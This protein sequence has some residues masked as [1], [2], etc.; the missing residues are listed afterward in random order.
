MSVNPN[1]RIVLTADGKGVTNTIKQ[2]KGEL[3]SLG[4]TSKST[5]DRSATG[6]KGYE[7]SIRS[8]KEQTKQLQVNT[9][10]LATGMVG[11]GTGIAAAYTSISN[12]AKATAR[13]E[14]AEVAVMRIE[15]Q[16]ATLRQRMNT[17]TQ[18]G[19]AGTEKYIVTVQKLKTAMTDLAIK[20]K[21]VEINAGLVQDTYI[22]FSTSVLNTA[23]SSMFIMQQSLKGVSKAM[24]A[25][26]FHM[27]TTMPIIKA[28]T[29]AMIT[30]GRAS[31]FTATGIKGVSAAL[32]ALMRA[33][34]YLLA[35]GAA[36]LAWE[37]NTANL[38]GE[39]E[40]LAGVNLG[41]TD[42]LMK[43]VEGTGDA[44]EVSNQF[45]ETLGQMN[46]IGGQVSSTFTTAGGTISSFG[47]A[48]GTAKQ[49]IIDYM[50]AEEDA[51]AAYSESWQAMIKRIKDME[52]ELPGSVERGEMG[53]ERQLGFSISEL[54]EVHGILQQQNKE[55][56][57]MNDLQDKFTGLIGSGMQMEQARLLLIK[58]EE[59]ALRV[60][61]GTSEDALSVIS[62]ELKLRKEIL[63]TIIAEQQELK[64][65]KKF[66]DDSEIER[67]FALKESF[68]ST[69]NNLLAPSLS[70]ATSNVYNILQ[71]QQMQN[72][73]T[74]NIVT[75]M[76]NAQQ[77][78]YAMS[79]NKQ[80]G[81]VTRIPSSVY[82]QNMRQ[83]MSVK[84][85][86][87]V[88]DPSRL[89]NK[90]KITGY[91][92]GNMDY[93]T[94]SQQALAQGIGG[95]YGAAIQNYA[96]ELE[97]INTGKGMSTSDRQKIGAAESMFR[98]MWHAEQ[99]YEAVRQ[100]GGGKSGHIM[101]WQGG[102]VLP[103]F[104]GSL[105]S[106]DAKLTADI[107]KIN[108]HTTKSRSFLVDWAN[109]ARRIA[110][111]DALE[112]VA[113]SN[114][115]KAATMERAGNYA[116]SLGMSADEAYQTIRSGEW[117]EQSLLDQIKFQQQQ[118]AMSTGVV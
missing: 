80:T 85:S 93:M 60:N 105:Q 75:E 101:R 31:I 45:N 19:Q 98:E 17:M 9:R 81:K 10:Q 39:I 57:I 51:L 100:A 111:R 69:V 4:T 88:Q 55:A 70:E 112:V 109:N 27:L 118:E 12:L 37:F 22:L 49:S 102:N 65:N 53:V 32:W 54:K 15:D 82:G 6:M 72:R 47:T 5:T 96:A 90:V 38:R 63:A 103:E 99:K 18:R 33:H 2:V 115:K 52:K 41:L 25:N 58:A 13:L 20:E 34:P 36:F 76:I 97:R 104:V 71:K 68:T 16:I 86:T 116:S 1:A 89:Q 94:R 40:K 113:A 107:T 30:W 92:Q 87:W 29:G 64:K 3:T 35:I 117:G 21:D 106:I 61:L 24:I 42:N 66:S 114:A 7:N 108:A 95:G 110:E 84:G 78:G 59:Q 67:E 74:S 91:G 62:K 11:L 23:I 28:Q 56:M 50:L 26:K 77:D 14:K 48:V 43:M 83:G 46:E 44:K 79:I 73:L 8:A